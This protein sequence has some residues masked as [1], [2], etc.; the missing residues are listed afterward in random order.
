MCRTEFGVLAHKIAGASFQSAQ[1]VFGLGGNYEDRKIT[2]SLDLLERLHD[3]E[4]V[5]CWHLQVE[6]DQ[7]VTV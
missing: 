6:K 3:L 5:Q 2:F 4:S 7:V 1:L